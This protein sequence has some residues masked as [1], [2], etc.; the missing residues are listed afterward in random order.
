MSA[1]NGVTNNTGIELYTK[2]SDS[3]LTF[4]P[5]GPVITPQIM[6]GPVYVA[7]HADPLGSYVQINGAKMPNP[8]QLGDL[9]T[10]HIRAIFNAR[11]LLTNNGP[12]AT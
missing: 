12:P 8:T 7:G 9:N 6:A 1:A 5:I 3:P 2:T 4:Q 10:G 11:K